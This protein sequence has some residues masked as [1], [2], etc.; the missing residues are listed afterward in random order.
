MERTERGQPNML[1]GHGVALSGPLQEAVDRIAKRLGN[2][3]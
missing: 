2:E 3:V 1:I